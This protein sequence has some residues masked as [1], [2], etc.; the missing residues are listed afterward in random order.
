VRFMASPPRGGFVPAWSHGSRAPPSGQNNGTATAEPPAGRF[1]TQKGTTWPTPGGG[2]GGRGRAPMVGGGVDLAPRRT[3]PMVGAWPARGRDRG[4]EAPTT[5]GETSASPRPP[6]RRA[7]R[8]R[9]ARATRP[10]SEAEPSPPVERPVA[11]ALPR[12][13]R[14]RPG[15]LGP[16]RPPVA[17]TLSE[18]G[19]P[20]QGPGRRGGSGGAG[21]AD[22]EGRSGARQQPGPGGE[23]NGDPEPTDDQRGP[24]RSP[25]RSRPSTRPCRP[26]RTSPTTHEEDAM[27]ARR[28]PRT[29]RRR[30]G[31]STTSGP[32]A[33]ARPAG[34][35]CRG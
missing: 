4:A 18:G 12:P 14:L 10:W 17:Q 34:H 26:P 31:S 29:T 5:R 25:D 16:E 33:A 24:G 1:L 15:R 6:P 7:V 22:R 20:R 28:R 8:S 9:R 32:G 3:G 35:A 2:R 13:L 11:R 19:Q 21:R 30:P 27:T 23:A